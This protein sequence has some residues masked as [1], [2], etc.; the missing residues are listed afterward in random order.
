MTM[1]KT[2]ADR[3][4]ALREGGAYALLAVPVAL[5]I[6]MTQL[7][8]QAETPAQ[9]LPA[10]ALDIAA[11][12]GMQT[13]VL[14]GGCFWGV[15][16]VFQHVKG[17]QNVL[18]GYSGGTAFSADYE[19][20]STGSTDHAESVQIVFDPKQVTFGQI[21]QVFFSVALDPT[22]VGGQGPDRGPQ[23]RSEVFYANAEQKK[24][25]E[26]Y[27]AQL[28]V[29]H[30]LSQP[31]ATRVD[32]LVHFY[33]AEAYHQDYLARNPGKP[34]IAYYDMPKVQSLKKLFPET[35]AETP[36]LSQKVASK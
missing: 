22:Q 25:A 20:V 5:G 32:R 9:R 8:A 10:P 16:G 7:P 35:Y 4:R 29:A 2:L 31:I 36:V 1:S 3:L 17:V 34:Y 11:S 23:Y 24:V 6:A 18:S 26:A 33:T 12:D 30:L 15:Q 13:A 21:L 14:A 19:T 27:I 28:D